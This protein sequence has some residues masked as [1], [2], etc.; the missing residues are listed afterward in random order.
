MEAE[1]GPQYMSSSYHR[2]TTVL[3]Q[4]LSLPSL[5]QNLMA[6]WQVLVLKVKLTVVYVDGTHMYMDQRPRRSSLD[7]DLSFGLAS[8]SNQH[9]SNADFFPQKT[10]QLPDE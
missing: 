3:L 5:Q 8:S 10:S 6:P 2:T 7:R 9:I 4:S 1:R